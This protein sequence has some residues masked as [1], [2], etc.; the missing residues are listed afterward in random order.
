MMFRSLRKSAGFS[1][2]VI[3][4][5]A[6]GIGANTAR[7]SVID[8]VLFH[9]FRFRSLDRLVEINGLT[10]SG[11]K[12]GNAPLEMD[13]FANNVHA[14]EQTAVWRWQNL[15]L[16]GVDSAESIFAVEVSQNL[17]DMLGVS[18]VHGRTL[19]AGDFNSSAPPV[20]VIS[21]R[22]WRKH[23]HADA[24]I[25]GRQI[26]LDGKGY[27]VVGV[28]GPAFVFTNPAHQVWIPSRPGLIAAEELKHYFSTMARLRPGIS[29]E[30][31][32][33]EMDA[34][35]PGLPPNPERT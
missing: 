21:D 22:L 13:F 4:V 9:P 3:S 7:F 18:P 8:K 19:L 26:L 31:A 14:F 16:T 35:T 30:Q 33:K 2:V 1:A 15:V 17:F 28:M 27:P 12:T 23:F 29:I 34:G 25:V 11:K 5:L 24:A 20:A 6:L 32:Q 10:T